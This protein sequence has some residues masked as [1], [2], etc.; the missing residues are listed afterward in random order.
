MSRKELPEA[1]RFSRYVQEG[2]REALPSSV[3]PQVVPLAPPQHIPDLVPSGPTHWKEM[4]PACG[5]PAQSP[6]NIDLHLVQRDPTLGPFI[7]QGYNTAPPGPWTLEND[8]HTG[9]YPTARIP[10]DTS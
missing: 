8:G 4:A 10:T 7:L 1:G 3:Y 6:I 2:G 5:G 9:Q